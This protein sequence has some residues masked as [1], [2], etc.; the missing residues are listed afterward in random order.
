MSLCVSSFIRD[1]RTKNDITQKRFAE[2]V[3]VTDK[4]VSKWECEKGYPDVMMLPRL[5]E[6]FGVR[7]DDLFV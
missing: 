7:I 1:Y 2:L 5:A 6:I 3:G 4:S